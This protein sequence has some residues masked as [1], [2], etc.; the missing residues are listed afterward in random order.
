MPGISQAEIKRIVQTGDT[1]IICN[2]FSEPGYVVKNGLLLF[3]YYDGPVEKVE[4][5]A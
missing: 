5:S 2:G 3:E 4:K 1:V